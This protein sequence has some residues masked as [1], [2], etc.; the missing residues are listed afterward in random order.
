[1]GDILSKMADIIHNKSWAK[2]KVFREIDTVILAKDKV[3]GTTRTFNYL[4]GLDI[5]EEYAK[6]LASMKTK[7][8]YASAGVLINNKLYRGKEVL[9]K[10]KGRF[11][12]VMSKTDNSN[13]Q[14][15]TGEILR[16]SAEEIIR[17]D[18]EEYPKYPR[19]TFYV[20]RC[21]ELVPERKISD[22]LTVLYRLSLLEP[23]RMS[24]EELAHLKGRKVPRELK[25]FI[26]YTKTLSLD[27]L[28]ELYKNLN[29]NI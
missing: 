16:V 12:M 9:D 19:Y 11:V 23:K 2:M 25:K 29:N 26:E 14:G 28:K 3:K 22:D 21:A 4:T 17:Y 8:W 20:G 27:K 15:D 24:I 5:S 13:I 18:N 1:M 7:N 10:K 6:A